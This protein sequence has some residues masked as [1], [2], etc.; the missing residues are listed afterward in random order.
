MDRSP[1][2]PVASEHRAKFAG[3]LAPSPAGVTPVA[4]ARRLRRAAGDAV[5]KFWGRTRNRRLGGFKFRREVLL[6]PFV[7][8]FVCI[9]ARLIVEIDGDQHAHAQ[10][11][12]AA[13]SR[14]LERMGYAVIRIPTYQVLHDLVHVLDRVHW[15]L[16]DRMLELRGR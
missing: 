15:A 13:R 10:T 16:E 1:P 3:A 8:D 12:D 14:Y 6:G 11:Y 2:K 4:R 7:A 9:E 5:R